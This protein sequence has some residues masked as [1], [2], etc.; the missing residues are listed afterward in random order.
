[1]SNLVVAAIIFAVSLSVAAGTIPLI[2]RLATRWQLLD[3]PDGGR[4]QHLRPVPRLGGIAVFAGILAALGAMK[5]AGYLG[6][7]SMQPITPLLPAMV[8]SCCI[9]FAIGLLD[10]LR[11]VKPVIKLSGQTVAALIVIGAGFGIDQISLGPGNSISLGMAGTVLAVIWLVG[12]SNSYNLVDGLDGL[13]GTVGVIAL[14]TLALAATALGV[15][16][17]AFHCAALAGALVGFL[18]FNLSPAR[19][20]LGDSGSLVVGFLL[21]ILSIEAATGGDGEL[22]ALVPIFALSYLLLDTGLAM[23]RRWLRGEPLSRAD[24][25]HVHHQL[26]ALGLSNGR[27]VALVGA[28]SFALGALGLAASFMPP[29]A[30]FAMA[31]LAITAMGL[32]F[33]NAIRWLDYHELLEA[34]AS[35]ASAARKA[36]MVIRDRINARDLA[37]LVLRADSLDELQDVLEQGAPTFRFA[38]MQLGTNR[39]ELPGVVRNGI[40]AGSIWKLEYPISCFGTGVA[41]AAHRG[42]EPMVLTIWCQ[43]SARRPAGAERVAQILGPAIALR[44]QEVPNDAWTPVVVRASGSYAEHPEPQTVAASP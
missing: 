5:V 15:E 23:A 13:A 27:A 36:R 6:I 20:F 18:L 31:A 14:A 9:L 22:H 10:D 44:L 38:H 30:T 33:F 4:R 12:M 35:V 11:G 3:H 43:L 40:K 26:R 29:Q 42:V 37:A 17:V 8:V 28:C 16:T 21:A 41:S 32:M 25:R 34:G 2:I 24:G 39:R 7:G 19:I 1:M